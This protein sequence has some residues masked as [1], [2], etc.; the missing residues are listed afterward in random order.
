M[1]NFLFVLLSVALTA[2]SW[3]IY[4]PLMREGVV[5]MKGSHL[6]PFICV[7][8]SYF[9]IAVVVPFGVL[10]WRPESGRWTTTGILWSFIAG[11]VT[12][13]GALGIILAQVNGG[14]PIYVMPLV[15]GGAPVVNTFMSMY[16]AKT[17]RQA[18]PIFYAG[19]ILVVA[20]AVT[21]LIFNPAKSKARPAPTTAAETAAAVPAPVPASEPS[22]A[23]A[24]AGRFKHWVLVPC[25]IAMTALCWGAYGPL[26][27]K[28][29]V[30]M[31]GSRLRPF[32]SVGMAYF[33]IA[34]LA[35]LL[36]RPFTADHGELTTSGTLWSLAVGVAGAVGSL[37]VI[38]AF[39]FGGKPVYV[40]PLIFGLA[41]VINTFVSIASAKNIGEINP[42]FYAG[43]I[44]V[45]AGAV[46]VLIFAPKPPHAP[47]AKKK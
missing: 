6:L 20:G 8:V 46:T 19:L 40:M 34:V 22:D 27:H 28:G 24:E 18:G 36:I 37:G 33:L 32:I 9:L 39:T 31:Q 44:V 15:F 23:H 7:G 17:Y 5:E 13:V 38:L 29:Q 26:L 47:M 3:G 43:L 1:S 2:V 41:P 42:L 30:A 25:F 4:G 35:P 16:M 12:A 11:V 14:S 45:V 10:K 21:V